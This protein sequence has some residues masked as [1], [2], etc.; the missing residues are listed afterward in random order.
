MISSV[1]GWVTNGGLVK[2]IGDAVVGLVQRAIAVRLRGPLSVDP[3]STWNQKRLLTADRVACEE[4]DSGRH[5]CR[6][7]ARSQ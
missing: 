4:F 3:C 6:Q 1:L 7:Q 5:H 2:V